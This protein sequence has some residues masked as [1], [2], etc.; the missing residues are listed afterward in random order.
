MNI[1]LLLIDHVFDIDHSLVAAIRGGHG[2][3]IR[4]LLSRGTCIDCPPRWIEKTISTNPISDTSPA[5]E[6]MSTPLAEAIR[7]N[8]YELIDEFE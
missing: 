3:I 4:V 7:A 2:A 6:R 1:L 8:D 5:N